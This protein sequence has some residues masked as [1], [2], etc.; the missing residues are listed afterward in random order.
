[1]IKLINKI[2]LAIAIMLAGVATSV[3][4]T[5]TVPTNCTVVSTNIALGGVLGSGG[6]VTSGGIVTM[7][8]G[9]S[10]NGGTYTFTGLAELH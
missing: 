1:M 9:V 2:H 8:D 4:Q 5:V 7:P 3:A 6:K 10:P